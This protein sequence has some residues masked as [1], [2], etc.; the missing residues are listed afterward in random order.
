MPIHGNEYID[1]NQHR[2][3]EF[4]DNLKVSNLIT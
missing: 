1:H 3:E 4:A 2:C